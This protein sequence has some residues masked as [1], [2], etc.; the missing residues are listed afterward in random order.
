V[1][2][3][4]PIHLLVT[5]IVMPQISGPELAA[6]LKATRPEMRTLFLSGYTGD[7]IDHD[8]ILDSTT[9]LLLKPIVPSA[10][11]RAVR[12]VLEAPAPS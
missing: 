7:A 11:E 8:S 6:R 3:A 4:G 9:M 10:F 2:H 1:Q 5:D 12:T